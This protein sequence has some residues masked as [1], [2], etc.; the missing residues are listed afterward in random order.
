RFQENQTTRACL[1]QSTI[2]PVLNLLM[3]FIYFTVLFLYNVRLTLLL[4]AFVIPILALTVLVTPK[5]KKFAREVFSVTTDAK[6]YLMETLGG[7]ET[8]KGMGIER[9]VRLKWETKYA[10]ALEVQYRSQSFNIKV[11]LVGQMLNS[12]TTIAVLWVGADLVLTRELTIG[13]LI[14]FNALMG[15][16]LAPL[17]GM[18][19]RSEERR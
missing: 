10:K 14:A 18:V 1:T 7:A 9:P 5:A 12:A 3:I 15:S 4:I 17:M 6:S 16:V 2:T 11:G 13:Q 8:V 19:G